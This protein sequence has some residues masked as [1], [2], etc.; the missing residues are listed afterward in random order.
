[1]A[2]TPPRAFARARAGETVLLVEDNDDV[3]RFGVSALDNLGY[4]VLEAR[5]GPSALR[6]LDTLSGAPV[7]LL[8]T[9]VVLP[10]GMTGT[11]LAEAFRA[12]RPRVPVLFTSGYTRNAMLQQGN[13][14]G[15]CRLLA[16]P[17]SIDK[18][19]VSVREALDA[20]SAAAAALPE[21]D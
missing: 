14:L 8:F 10:G 17:Y 16:K 21:S 6:L 18:L 12:R 9:D 2:G 20:N 11:A 1:M 19:A 3:R 15:D 7:H 5:D 4:R 13:P